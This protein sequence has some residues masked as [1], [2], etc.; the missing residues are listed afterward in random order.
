MT[1]PSRDRQGSSGENPRAWL[2]GLLSLLGRPKREGVPKEVDRPIAV[3][4]ANFAV[5]SASAG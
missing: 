5:A 2:V 4:P 3:Q 1:Y